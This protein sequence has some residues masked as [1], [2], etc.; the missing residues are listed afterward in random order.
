M[1][2]FEIT[3]DYDIPIGGLCR[4]SGDCNGR[5]EFFVRVNN[6]KSNYMKIIP[7][8][9][10]VLLMSSCTRYSWEWV[11]TETKISTVGQRIHTEPIGKPKPIGDTTIIGMMISK[12]KIPK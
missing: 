2:E 4:S 5:P 11:A 3:D 6:A 1:G 12:K 8:I 10:I 7:T 9:L